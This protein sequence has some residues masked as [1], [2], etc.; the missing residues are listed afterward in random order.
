[1]FGRLRH[2]GAAHRLRLAH[3]LG[4]IPALGRRYRFIDCP[5]PGSNETVFKSAH[6]LVSGRHAAGYG[7]NARYVFDLS[8]LDANHLVL[9]GGQDGHPG[10]PAFLDQAELFRRGEY[11]SLPLKPE[12]A[13]ARFAQST[14]L[15]PA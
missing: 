6:G 12:T 4:A 5:W 11:L 3:P 13:R 10:S 8:D 7:S 9:L 1:V 14:V 15:R 2:W